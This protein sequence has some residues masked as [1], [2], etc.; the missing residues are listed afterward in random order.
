[1]D[2]WKSTLA[3]ACLGSCLAASG[4]TISTGHDAP[5][6]AVYSGT[7]SIAWTVT[8]STSAN[9]CADM[10]A[11][12]LDIEIY[13]RDGYLTASVYPPCEAFLEDIDLPEGAYQIDL[14]MVDSH[15]HAV[16]TTLTLDTRV[17]D[18]SSTD[19]DVDFPTSSFF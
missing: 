15:N 14:T 18:E 13:D 4:C 2:L 11:D 6:P 19:I 8:H 3:A 1:M 17:Y 16:S 10:Y 12:A 5:A 9:A 7:L